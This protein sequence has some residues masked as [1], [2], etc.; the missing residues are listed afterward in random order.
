MSQRLHYDIV[1]I[2]SGPAGHKAAIQGAKAG[3]RVAI[4]ERN[5]EVGGACVHQG[6]IPSKTLRE[7]AMNIVR[8]NRIPEIFDYRLRDDLKV[9]H[10]I[11]RLEGVIQAHTQFMSDQLRRNSITCY[12]GRA[13][14]LSAHELHISTPGR[15]SL[16]CS[17]DY[18]VIATGSRPRTLS[19]IPVD[20]EHI[21]DSDSILSLI[22]LP[23]TLTVLGGGII[24][25]EYASFFS[26][27]GVQVT[28]ID[29]AE[30]PLRFMDPEIVEGFLREFRQDGGTYLGRQTIREV[31]WDGLSQVVTV[32]DNGTAVKSEKL[33][34]AL[35]RVANIED[36]GLEAAG[37][38]P[39][40]RGLIPVNQYC[41]TAI[42]HIYAVGDVIGPP[43][44]ASCSMEQGRRAVRHALGLDLGSPPEMVPIGIY[45][46]PE[47][48]CVGLGEDE[49]RARFGGVQVGRAHFREIA[50][51]QISGMTDGL[52]KMIAD[53]QGK[54]LLG[55][56]IVGDGATELIH[57]AQMG[58]IAHVDVESFVEN[59]FNFPTLAE[60][61]RVAALDIAKR[62]PR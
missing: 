24:A 23:K 54:K 43:S 55:V 34:M 13:R 3:K 46:I 48:A 11:H 12:H 17:A 18:I 14:F 62:V 52:L 32:L 49:A 20:H 61:Y 19:H 29:Q 6:T 42:P 5:K 35:G 60:A 2:G 10:L 41:Q 21:L 7:C 25:S 28:M 22:Y 44:L 59:I 27:L 26:Q 47:M 45:T 4:I 56:H 57:I 36:L 50:R 40:P 30:R 16:Q 58:L 38:K 39:T 53:L 8:F 51:G 1:V 33:L 37:I 31:F 15:G 9:P